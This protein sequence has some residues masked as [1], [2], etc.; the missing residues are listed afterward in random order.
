MIEQFKSE[1]AIF[2]IV[3]SDQIKWFGVRQLAA[4]ALSTLAATVVGSMTGRRELM[5]ALD[6]DTPQ[7][8]DFSGKDEVWLDYVADSGDGW[9]PTASIAWLV[10]RDAI[11]LKRDGR[12]TPQPIPGD[13]TTEGEPDIEDTLV[14]RHGEILI[15]G[16]DEAYPVASAENYQG[17]LVDPFKCARYSQT[18]KRCVFALPGNHDWYDGLTSFI[19]LF[20]QS[21]GAR[22]WIGAWQAQQRRSYFAIRLPH[23]WWLWGVDM[24][25]E[26]DLDPPQYDYFRERSKELAPGDRVIL[27]APSPVW[28]KLQGKDYEAERSKYRMADKLRIITSLALGKDEQAAVPVVLTGDNHYYVRHLAKMNGASRQYIVCGGGGAF[29]LGTLQV[30]DTVKIPYAEN[31]MAPAICRKKFPDDA[32]SRKLRKGALFFPKINIVFAAVLALSQVITLWLVS[33]A[34]GS[35]P[36]ACVFTGDWIAQAMCSPFS[37]DGLLSGLR[38]ALGYSALVQ[39]PALVLWLLLIIG[40]FTGLAVSSKE[41]GKS[42]L[43]A[44]IAGVVHALLQI[45][46]ALVCVWVVAQIVSVFLDAGGE[47]TGLLVLLL[48]YPLVHFY[49]GLLFGIYLFLSHVLFGIHDQEVFS[50]QGIEDYKSF[51]R[52]KISPRGLEI[53]P[54]GLLRSSRKWLGAQGVTVTNP[55]GFQTFGTVREVSIP[56]GCTRVFDPEDPLAPHLIE[57]P[58]IIPGKRNEI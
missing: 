39:S 55:K 34:A 49:C 46:G 13:C 19:R 43:I 11:A 52:M 40:A 50:S 35:P 31:D 14:L 38:A 37:W 23:G 24:A 54:V 56:E 28:L 15:L 1:A 45:V 22:R 32:H 21:V 57:D 4:T 27:C 51:L 25:L 5:A 20:C 17:R 26:D 42:G 2:R 7:P 10:G 8:A 6:A 29:G 53:Y 18:P 33:S 3:Q 16:G 12:P 41:P 9:N 36:A 44:S 58:I 47:S 48:S 30:K